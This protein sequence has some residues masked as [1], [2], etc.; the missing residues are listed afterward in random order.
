MP[1]LIWF[2]ED[3]RVDDNTALAYA[4]QGAHNGVIALF[5]ITPASWQEHDLAPCRVDF[6]LRGLAL[7]QTDLARLH[8]PL[9]ILHLNHFHDI[10][11]HLA[12]LCHH[13]Q[14]ETVHANRQYEYH[15]QQRDKKVA[16][17]LAASGVDFHLYEDVCIIPPSTLKTKQQTAY[18]VFTPYKKAW[19]ARLQQDG[20]P[21][22]LPAPKPQKSIMLTL[23]S[24]LPV[25][26]AI[27]EQI[28]A[29]PSNIPTT[30]WPAGETI[31]QAKLHDFIAQSVQTYHQTRDIPSYSGTSQLSPYF[32]SGMLSI[33]RCLHALLDKYPT[34]MTQEKT[35]AMVWLNELIWRDFYK[36]ILALFPRVSMNQP[37]KLATKRLVWRNDLA[38]LR[39][40]QQ[41]QTGFPIVDAAMRQ[42][43]QTGW[44]HNRCRMITA[45]FFS[46]LLWLDWRLG[47]QW[48]MRSLIDGDLAAN[49][50]GWQWCASTGNDAVPYFRIFNPLRQ[51]EQYD[52]DGSYIRKYCPE[53]AVCDNH[54]IHAPFERNP[55]LASQLHYP[56]PI[57][58]YAQARAAALAAFKAL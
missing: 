4:C 44:M 3:L 54:T 23:P 58:D 5:V 16:Q 27:P 35:G 15:E 25:N 49:N 20:A 29:F 34:V 43:Q 8:I 28:S 19:L 47:E 51:S 30:Y 37:F 18:T 11:K 57:I 33:R 21:A 10:P 52:P 31:A 12:A 53:L 42:L 26:T 48:F 1:A 41:G 24:H 46:K 9:Y 55:L 36:M 39:A 40:W 45:M 38:L 56:R 14:V 13:W 6:M 50:G 22:L 32:A 2:R 17:A 7:L